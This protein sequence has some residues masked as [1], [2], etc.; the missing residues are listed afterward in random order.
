[1]A[2]TDWVRFS[3]LQAAMQIY[4]RVGKSAVL[5]LGRA[6]QVIQS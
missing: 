6:L 1:M 5:Q 3:G 4:A 2:L